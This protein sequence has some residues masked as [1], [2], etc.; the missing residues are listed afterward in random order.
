MTAILILLIAQSPLTDLGDGTYNGY[1]GG[2]YPGGSNVRPAS[3]EE[4]GVSIA[5]TIQPLDAN[6]NPDPNGKIVMIGIGMSNTRMEFEP[7]MTLAQQDNAVNPKL[8]LVCGAMDGQTAES[9]SQSNHWVWSNLGTKLQQAGV[10]GKQV[11]VAFVK[12]TSFWNQVPAT[13]PDS[14][15]TMMQRIILSLQNL[16][17]K[18]PNCKLAYLTSRTYGGYSNYTGPSPEPSAYESGF[19][20]KWVIQ[21]QLEGHP[22][23]SLTKVPWLSW[24]PYLW[25]NGLG[26]DG[27]AGGIPGRSDGLE[28][29]PWEFYDGTHPNAAAASKVAQM[30]LDHLKNDATA[31]PW[32][33][34]PVGTPGG[35]ATSGGGSSPGGCGMV[36][37]EALLVLFCLG[38][39]KIR[40]T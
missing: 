1:P 29:G 21:H 36:G 38:R 32:F 8:V 19:A 39:R 15:G 16:K 3:H 12:L 7:F 33:L 2:L 10:T 18:Y 34:A 22:E 6:G 25:A 14:A 26:S 28:W 30:I 20:M 35:A 40:R 4:T 24:G 37:L 17:S 31:Q 13:F 11:Q 27:V 23:L 9:W 5:N